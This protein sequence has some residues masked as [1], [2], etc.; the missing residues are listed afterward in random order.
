MCVL[1]TGDRVMSVSSGGFLRHCS[2]EVAGFDRAG[3]VD[4]LDLAAWIEFHGAAQVA[5]LSRTVT[6]KGRKTVEVVYFHHQ[7]PQL[8]PGHPGRLC[9][10]PLGD[11]ADVSA[12][13][14]SRAR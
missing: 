12:T 1:V 14:L 7:R 11:R 9:P 6:K 2:Y 5:Y 8:R 10:Q 13:A 3:S 4:I